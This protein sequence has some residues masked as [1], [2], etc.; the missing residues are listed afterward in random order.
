VAKMIRCNESKPE[1]CCTTLSPGEK[2]DQQ[3][4]DRK[5]MLPFPFHQCAK[6]KRSKRSQFNLPDLLTIFS[7]LLKLMT[8][9][10]RW[11]T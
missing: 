9:V 10:D 1:C 3:D 4:D 11:Y 2:A 7:L 6:N 5:S 8:M